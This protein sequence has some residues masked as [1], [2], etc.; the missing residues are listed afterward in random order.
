MKPEHR[1]LP[2]RARP[3]HPVHH[4]GVQGV[5][6]FLGLFAVFT[7]LVFASKLSPAK[8]TG[9]AS[10]ISVDTYVNITGSLRSICDTPIPEGTSLMSFHC[11]PDFHPIDQFKQNMSFEG[12]RIRALFQYT[13]LTNGK[14]YAYNDSLPNWTVQSLT[15]FGKDDGIYFV[16]QW[17]SHFTYNGFFVNNSAIQLRPG[18]N[19]VGYPSNKTKLLNESLGSINDTYRVIRALER[20][21]E[22]GVYLQDVPPPMGDPLTNTSPY[23][24]YW[25]NMS[26]G[27][28][29]VVTS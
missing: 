19:M 1:I 7:L 9:H 26:V 16:V 11:L 21:E 23:Y 8:L 2:R 17:G 18:W 20:T 3:H 27:D 28:T 29:W 14:W 24:G 13:P 15:S 5:F 22:A 4:P 10:N 6:L 12:R 25:I